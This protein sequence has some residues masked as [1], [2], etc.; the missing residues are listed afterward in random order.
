[1][2]S[3]WGLC[4]RDR[5]RAP[6]KRGKM[7]GAIS[8]FFSLWPFRMSVWS[9]CQREEE[10]ECEADRESRRETEREPLG[11]NKSALH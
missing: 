10:G 3:P 5:C 4:D 2:S 8:L 11:S 9:V 7:T 1:M 6:V